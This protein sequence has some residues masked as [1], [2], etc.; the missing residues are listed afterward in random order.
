MHS[1]TSHAY[2]FSLSRSGDNTMAEVVGRVSHMLLTLELYATHFEP[3]FLSRAKDFYSAE[4]IAAITALDTPRFLALIDRRLSEASDLTTRLLDVRTR[5]ALFDVIECA[6]LRPHVQT[7][8]EKGFKQLVDEDRRDDLRRLYLLLKRI[9]CVDSALKGGWSV[10][11]RLVGESIIADLA[12]ATATANAPPAAAAN[13]ALTPA[14]ISAV[15][16]AGERD[17]SFVEDVLLL[18]EKLEV[19]LRQSFDHKESLALALKMSFEHFLNLN[20]KVTAEQLARYVD[21][22]MRGEKGVTEQE[23]EAKLDSVMRVFKF[24]MEK[25]IF[26]AFYKKHLSKRLLLGM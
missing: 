2:S 21:R 26:E 10:Y 11:I 1:L 5:R 13:G 9:D 24:L 15:A 16:A 14:A 3:T 22:K 23:V 17:K 4:G 19:I 8:M 18:L 25:D 7:V 12:A 6:L 20:Q